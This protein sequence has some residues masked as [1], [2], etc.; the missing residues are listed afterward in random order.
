[1]I[2]LSILAAISFC[3]NTVFLTPSRILSFCLNMLLAC[4]ARKL[5]RQF[6]FFTENIA[7]LEAFLGAFNKHLKDVHELEMFY[8]DEVLESLISHSKAAVQKI[9]DFYDVFS[10]DDE[11][12]DLDGST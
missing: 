11:E 1:M 8:G 5:T 10:L 3:L 6:L 9:E 4:Y 12:E 7:D 2:T